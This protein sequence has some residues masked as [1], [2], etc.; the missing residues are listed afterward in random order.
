MTLLNLICLLLFS[1]IGTWMLFDPLPGMIIR[2]FP[3]IVGR[4]TFVIYYNIVTIPAIVSFTV[5][6]WP[7]TMMP[8]YFDLVDEAMIMGITPLGN[9]ISEDDEDWDD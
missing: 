6:R 9:E 1:L 5:Y 3:E 4:I 8:F 2:N 7:Q